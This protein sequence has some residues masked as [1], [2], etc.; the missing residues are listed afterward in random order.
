MNK[1]ARVPK[2]VIGLGL[3][4]LALLLAAC[5]QS[6]GNWIVFVS[7]ADGDSD[8]YVLNPETGEKQRMTA[9]SDRDVAPQWSPDRRQIAYLSGEVGQQEIHVIDPGT[10]TINR[11]TRDHSVAG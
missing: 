9:N 1:F 2:L 11:L 7:E 4:A 5:G 6:S 3:L 8:I 10:Q